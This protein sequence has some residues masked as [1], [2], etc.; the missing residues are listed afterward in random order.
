MIPGFCESQC[1]EAT[2][3][4][5]LTI[6]NWK[7]GVALQVFLF[8]CVGANNRTNA[9]GLHEQF[10]QYPFVTYFLNAVINLKQIWLVV[11]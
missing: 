8:K 2:Y 3:N 5:L 1:C 11:T 6:K 9:A 10:Y 7:V 4:N